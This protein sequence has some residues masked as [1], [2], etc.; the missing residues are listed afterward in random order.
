MQ[1]LTVMNRTI[2]TG[3]VTACSRTCQLAEVMRII[4]TPRLN[5]PTV[6]TSVVCFIMSLVVSIHNRLSRNLNRSTRVTSAKNPST[7]PTPSSGTKRGKI[8]IISK[9]TNASFA[10]A[11]IRISPYFPYYALN[12]PI[13]IKQRPPVNTP[14]WA[15]SIWAKRFDFVTSLSQ[16]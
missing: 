14:V 16:I 8:T 2:T 3:E 10:K 15:I 13:F 12:P 1:W 5:T 4:K 7:T 9:N 6:I 11:G